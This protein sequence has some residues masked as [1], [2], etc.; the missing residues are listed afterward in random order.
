MKK[1]K[2]DSRARVLQTR[3]WVGCASPAPLVGWHLK[4]REEHFRSPTTRD[5][6]ASFPLLPL[7]AAFFLS[8]PP[9]PLLFVYPFISSLLCRRNQKSHTCCIKANYCLRCVYM[10]LCILFFHKIVFRLYLYLSYA[11]TLNVIIF[12]IVV[13]ECCLPL[14]PR[15][16]IVFL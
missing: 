2:K 7:F 4:K 13:S 14:I 3:F 5:L 9:L 16:N 12:S 11:F 1:K 15:A 8:F 10:Y 6:P